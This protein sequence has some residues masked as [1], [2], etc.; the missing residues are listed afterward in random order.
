MSRVLISDH[1]D[2]LAGKKAH[3]INYAHKPSL[4][5]HCFYA[6]SHISTPARPDETHLL[7]QA[8]G[9]TRGYQAGHNA[10]HVKLSASPPSMPHSDQ[11]LQSR[12][13]SNLV[14]AGKSA[15]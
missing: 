9:Q 10:K 12:K 2:Y 3:Q 6:R 7:D 8:P 5:I 4:F 11:S 15:P 13:A 1:S 14:H